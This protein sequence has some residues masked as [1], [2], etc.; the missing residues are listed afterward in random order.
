L[1]AAARAAAV[2]LAAKQNQENPSPTKLDQAK[3]L[4][5]IWFY[6]FE[7]GLFNGLRGIQIKTSGAGSGSVDTVQNALRLH[8]RLHFA[9]QAKASWLPR[10]E[11]L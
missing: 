5:F 3:Q 10:I 1:T 4:G 8:F 2:R 9:G 11:N 7:S 6:S